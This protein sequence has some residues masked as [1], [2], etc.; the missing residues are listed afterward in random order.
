MN[1]S[2]S[3]IPNFEK[4]YKRL[5]KKYPSLPDDLTAF[6]EKLKHN[7]TKGTSL[8]AGLY[9]VRLSIASKAQGQSGGARVITF[10]KVSGQAVLLTAI[11]DKSEQDTIKPKELK[12]LLQ[13][14][15]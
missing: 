2:V 7:P 6:I 1:Y 15:P 8:G 9:K 11:Y 4:Q 5:W 3:S 12:K 10:V 14:I 13:L